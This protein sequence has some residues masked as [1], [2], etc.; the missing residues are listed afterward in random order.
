DGKWPLRPFRA[1]HHTASAVALTG[2]GC[3]FH[4]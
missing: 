1:P 3:Q 2:G 4:K